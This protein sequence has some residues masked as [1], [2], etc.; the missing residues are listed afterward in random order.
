VASSDFAPWLKNRINPDAALTQLMA[1]ADA[2]ATQW[3]YQSNRMADYV[4]VVQA[5]NDPNEDVLLNTLERDFLIWKKSGEG[6]LGV[7]TEFA[8]L[9]TGLIVVLFIFWALFKTDLITVLSDA[10]RARGLITFLF[11]F[12]TIAVIFVVVIAVL[13]MDKD[14]DVDSRFSKAK[15]IITILVGILGT[16]I[17]FYFGNTRSAPTSVV[18]PPPSVQSPSPTVPPSSS[19]SSSVTPPGTA[20]PPSVPGVPQ[21]SSA[22]PPPAAPVTQ[23]TDSAADAP[24]ALPDTG[25]PPATPGTPR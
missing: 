17:G 19:P 8:L 7:I 12:I 6:W 18:E 2:H 1:F 21:G 20:A 11:A 24:S 14:Q 15:D 10:S 3:P 22:T 23:P 4:R 16:I 13:W 25:P 9:A 5:A